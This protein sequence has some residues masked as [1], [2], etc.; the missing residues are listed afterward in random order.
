MVKKRGIATRLIVILVAIIVVIA[1]V[2]AALYILYRP[3]TGTSNVLRIGVIMELTGD[4]ARDGLV[5]KRG[6][7][8]W[9]KVV[10]EKGGITIGGTRYSVELKYYDTRSDPGQAAAAVEKAISEGVDILLGPYSSANTLG[11]ISVL[12]KYGIPM[13]AGSPE[14]HLIPQQRSPWVFQTL[15]TSKES[16]LAFKAIIMRYQSQISKAA[17]LSANDAFSQGLAS[18]FRSIFNELG[19]S[20]VVD[21]TFPVD[22]TDLKPL[23]T[24]V[25]SA[26]PDLLVV[27]AH[28][29]HHILAIKALKETGFNPKMMIVH[30]GIDSPDVSMSVGGIAEGVLGLVMWTPKINWKDPIF[31]DV[32]NFLKIWNNTYPGISPDYT[33][34]SCAATASYVVAL[35]DQ[36]GLKPPL[37]KDAWQKLRDA[38]EKTRIETILGPIKYSTDPDHWHVNM[39]LVNSVYIVQFQKGRLL[40]VYPDTAKE[41]DLEFPKPPWG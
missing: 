41:A 5:C 10:Q 13:F 25:A 16:P 21:E 7:D 19:I 34:V 26:N 37:D 14:S 9:Y 33:G 12:N 32:N 39:E 4:L 1:G 28:P 27:A 29:T 2:G 18:T 17:M 3:P 23:I 22:I 40:I 6:Y 30:Y 35:L 24:K 15:L 38:A 36:L 8:L 31:G 20:L 11:T